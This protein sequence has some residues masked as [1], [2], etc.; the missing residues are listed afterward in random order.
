M[1]IWR[2]ISPLARNIF[3]PPYDSCASAVSMPFRGE[4]FDIAV[5][6]SSL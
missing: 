3:V 4:V 2:Q 1:P 5:L 6:A